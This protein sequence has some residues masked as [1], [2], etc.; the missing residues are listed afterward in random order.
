M[1]RSARDVTSYYTKKRTDVSVLSV[2]LYTTFAWQ[3]ARI[4]FRGCISC[5]CQR[6]SLKLRIATFFSLC[7]H[8]IT[9]LVGAPGNGNTRE[10]D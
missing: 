3:R 5:D 8:G 9:A 4:A 2:C 1:Q 7:K 6:D 10:R